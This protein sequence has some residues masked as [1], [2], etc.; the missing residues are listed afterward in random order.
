VLLAKAAQV[1]EDGLAFVLEPVLV[2]ETRGCEG[3]K[4]NE[5]LREHGSVDISERGGIAGLHVCGSWICK[6]RKQKV[7]R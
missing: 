6:C 4:D 3:D 2:G 1:E 5:S 7:E